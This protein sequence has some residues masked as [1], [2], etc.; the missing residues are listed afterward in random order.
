MNY[1]HTAFT[2]RTYR[3]WIFCSFGL[4]V[5]LTLLGAF[6]THTIVKITVNYHDGIEPRSSIYSL[7]ESTDDHA[8]PTFGPY[9]IV[10][11]NSSALRVDAGN[12][13]TLKELPELPLVGIETIEVNIYKD[14]AAEKY[15]DNSLGCTAYDKHEDIMLSYVCGKP[16][17]LTRHYRPVNPDDRWSNEIIASLGSEHG[18]IFSIEPFQDGAL[19]LYVPRNVVIESG[20]LLFTVSANGIK[21]ELRIPE[22]LPQGSLGATSIVTDTVTP[23]AEHFLLVNKRDGEVY[24][25]DTID[26]QT[27]SYKKHSLPEDI[28]NVFDTLSCQLHNL[29][30]YCIYGQPSGP[31]DS[32]AHD[33]YYDEERAAVVLAI[34]FSNTTPTERKYI[35]A[36][37]APVDNLHV[38]K[39]NTLFVTAGSDIFRLYLDE[40][41][42]TRKIYSSSIGPVA[43][44]DG[45]YFIRNNALYK[46]DDITDESY[47]IFRSNNLRLSNID[48]IDG[49]LFIN[50]YID[51]RGDKRL[52]TFKLSNSVNTAPE[53][54]PLT[55]YDSNPIAARLPY[56]SLLYTIDYRTDPADS[57][58]RSIILEIDAPQG[59]REQ[60]LAQL[61]RWGYNPTNLNI[62]FINYRN[63]F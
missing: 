39:S 24:L 13:S 52:F 25:A 1:I 42:A 15:T 2:Q 28:S 59:R 56:K 48:E 34:D 44:G 36:D 45:L 53:I 12:Y 43:A 55:T 41:Q 16:D 30:A 14:K 17:H 9:S 23:N 47:L 29:M 37:T 5:A 6:A 63:P 7:R 21:Q 3:F 38:T 11:K 35:L 60:V 19:G 49:E 27:V 46:V 10:S 54:P 18:S 61:E 57:T 40:T 4:A 50:A 32:E 51:G 58:G 20:L 33:K 62:E 26:G 8:I 22:S 31:P